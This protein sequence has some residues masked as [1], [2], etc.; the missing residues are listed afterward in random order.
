MMHIRHSTVSDSES[1]LSPFLSPSFLVFSSLY[2]SQ[3]RHHIVQCRGVMFN[4]YL[5]QQ[6]ILLDL[7]VWGMIRALRTLRLKLKL[8]GNYSM[9]SRMGSLMLACSCIVSR[10]L[11]H[12]RKKQNITW[13][14][15]RGTPGTTCKAGLSM[16][17]KTIMMTLGSMLTLVSG[18]GQLWTLLPGCNSNSACLKSLVS[19]TLVHLVRLG[20]LAKILEFAKLQMTV[21]MCR[22]RLGHRPV[23]SPGKPKCSGGGN[24]C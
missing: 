19:L 15:H 17:S 4:H 9:K 20:D 5:L 10:R 22:A 7:V 3:T 18:L 24:S 11:G 8:F 12:P 6:P 23:T 16:S 14:R 13:S 21:A 1:Q 2:C